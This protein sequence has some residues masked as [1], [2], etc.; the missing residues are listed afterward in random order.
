MYFNKNKSLVWCLFGLP[1]DF[2]LIFFGDRRALCCLLEWK[3]LVYSAYQVFID[4]SLKFSIFHWFR[5]KNLIIIDVVCVRSCSHYC[6]V[7][8]WSDIGQV[9]LQVVRIYV[10]TRNNLFTLL[11]NSSFA[12]QIAFAEIDVFK[13]MLIEHSRYQWN[14]NIIISF[15]IEEVYSLEMLHLVAAQS[16][17]TFHKSSYYQHSQLIQLNSIW[18]IQAYLLELS[19]PHNISC[20]SDE[21]P[22]RFHGIFRRTDTHNK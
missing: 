10:S 20:W 21:S 8:R 6:Y 12:Q 16:D 2:T 13:A 1:K 19:T 3:R 18:I 22:E 15:L 5:M 11:L 4:F 17:G 14:V 7:K 9:F